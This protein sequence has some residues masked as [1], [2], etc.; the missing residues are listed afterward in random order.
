MCSSGSYWL[1]LAHHLYTLGLSLVLKTVILLH[2]L[3]EIFT[4]LGVLQVFNSHIQPASGKL[5]FNVIAL[6]I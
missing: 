3:L 2:S 4:A 6:I 5:E 1:P